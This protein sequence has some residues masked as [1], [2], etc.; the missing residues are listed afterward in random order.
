MVMMM[1]MMC[2]CVCTRMHVC[3]CTC[4]CVCTHVRVHAIITC[5]LTFQPSILFPL[6]V[7]D[8]IRR[9]LDQLREIKAMV[10]GS[11]DEFVPL[12]VNEKPLM[13]LKQLLLMQVPSTINS[14]ARQRFAHLIDQ[15][16]QGNDHYDNSGHLYIIIIYTHS[17]MH[18]YTHTD[19]H[20]HKHRV[21][22]THTH[23]Q[24]QSHARTHAHTRTHIHT[25]SH[26]NASQGTVTEGQIF[27]NSL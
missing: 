26:T 14:A 18:A 22:H 6:T 9:T 8:K 20:T 5:L 23:T 2:V 12:S 10:E 16:L 17:C 7:K 1:M 11:H 3:V 21:T 15:A 19:A 13:E 24:T 4:V 25:I 27:K